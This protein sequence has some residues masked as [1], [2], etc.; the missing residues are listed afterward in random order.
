MTI[1]RL[2]RIISLMFFLTNSGVTYSQYNSVF[3]GISTE[4]NYMTMYCDAIFTDTYA[5]EKDTLVDGVMYKKVKDLGLFRE[6][7]NKDELW[8][9]AVNSGEEILLMNLNLEVG[10]IFEIN[11]ATYEVESILVMNDRK[12]VQFNYTPLNCG[13]YEKLRFVEGLGP[14]LGFQ[15]MLDDD[16]ENL[17]L[18]RCHSKDEETDLYFEDWFG[19][20]CLL[21]EL[22]VSE[23][24]EF[25]FRAFP[26]PFREKLN[27][28][29]E[30]SGNRAIS[31]F[32]LFGGMV[33][34]N[35]SYSKSLNLDTGHLKSGLYFLKIEDDSGRASRLITKQ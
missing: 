15:F 19:E 35:T 31:I 10:D 16:V 22:S 14:N 23:I 3:G 5:F 12:V 18:I 13:V 17:R 4:W 6:S 20:D 11:S 27:L 26:V 21:E 28:E 32:D 30:K 1:K 7:D 25:N 2:L 33:Y 29:F 9:K 34:Y 24:S 8:Y